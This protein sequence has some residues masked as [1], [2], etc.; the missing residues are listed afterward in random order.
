MDISVLMD[1]SLLMDIRVLMDVSVLYPL[2][3][4]IFSIPSFQT[5]LT[6][7][8]SASFREQLTSGV[9]F[10]KKKKIHELK[11]TNLQILLGLTMLSYIYVLPL[12]HMPL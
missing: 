6:V 8:E 10:H 7:F 5:D 4:G 9:L 11:P 3:A 2:R 1:I 12:D